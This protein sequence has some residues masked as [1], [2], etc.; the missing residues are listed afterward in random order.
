MEDQAA[1][2]P[3]VRGLGGRGLGSRLVGGARTQLIVTGVAFGMSFLGQVGVA[4]LFGFEGLGE[5]AAVTLVLNF[6]AVISLAGVPLSTS[7]LVGQALQQGDTARARQLGSTG[8]V[9]TLASSAVMVTIA[10]A[11]W[12]EIATVMQLESP[13]PAVALA[14]AMPFGALQAYGNQLF[15]ARLHMRRA[16]LIVLVQPATVVA[17]VALEAL[18][19]GI[20]RPGA[21]VIAANVVGGSTASI[22]LLASGYRP[23]ARRQEAG[24]ILREA[25]VLAPA[26]YGTLLTQR[27]DKLLVSTFLGPTALGA[28]QAAAG[29]VDAGMRAITTARWFLMPVYGRLAAET[30]NRL[31]RLRSAHVRLWSAYAILLMCGSIASANG[32]VATIYGPGTQAAQDPLRVLALGFE[33]MAIALALFTASAGVG[34]F[35]GALVVTWLTIPL[36]IALVAVLASSFGLIGAAVGRVAGLT[37]SALGYSFLSL[38]SGHDLRPLQR[39]A[40]AW[41]LGAAAAHAISFAPLIWPIRAALG[42]TTGVA[43]AGLVLFGEEERRIVRAMARLR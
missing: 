9:L 43:V 4:R 30:S 38:R 28:Y 41:I 40:I 24:R 7:R 6:A 18:F 17:A 2:D 1:I 22:L 29:M 19:P 35:R 16:G 42:I 3:E 11:F 13:L 21:I 39:A 8:S 31:E 32:L 25:V 37:F 5:Y 36:Q 10:L 33:P 27:S 14:F 26:A 12:N 20:V 15:Q 23:R 34:R